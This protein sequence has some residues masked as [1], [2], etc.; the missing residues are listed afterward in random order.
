MVAIPPILNREH[1]LCAA[2]TGS[3]FV[4]SLIHHCMQKQEQVFV[5]VM[6]FSLFGES[7]EELSQLSLSS[8]FKN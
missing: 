5:F 7:R 1:V 3:H 4:S 8:S 6:V 2:Q